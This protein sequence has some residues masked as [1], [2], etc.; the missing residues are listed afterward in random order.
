MTTFNHV[1]D[2]VSI[3]WEPS[4]ASVLREMQNSLIE[5]EKLAALGRLVAG[6]AHEINNPVGRSLTV[7]TALERKI[8]MIATELAEGK[9][10]R[11]SLLEFLEISREAS[12]QLVANLNHAAELIRSF[13]QVATDRNQPNQRTFDLGDLTEQIVLRL[14]PG[15]GKNNLTQGRAPARPDYDQ[16]SRALRAGA[17]EPLPQF[18]HP[19]VCR[20]QGRQHRDQ[21]AC[22]RQG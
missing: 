7:A 16:L 22:R 2:P 15:L 9:L 13:K 17:D 4:P 14:R 19:C 11:S 3:S 18:G 5:V 1:T 10:R 20:R 6:V 8:G 12:S 21:G